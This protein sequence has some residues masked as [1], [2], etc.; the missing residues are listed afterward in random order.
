VTEGDPAWQRGGVAA[1]VAV[2][3][4]VVGYP[5]AS[6]GSC[7]VLLESGTGRVTVVPGVGAWVVA[8][9]GVGCPAASRGVAAAQSQGGD[10]ALRGSCGIAGSGWR[11]GVG[12][13]VV[14]VVV[15]GWR[16]WCAVHREGVARAV[17]RSQRWEPLTL[18]LALMA[19]SPPPSSRKTCHMWGLAASLTHS[20]TLSLVSRRGRVR[21]WTRVN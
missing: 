16:W 19:S 15:V 2:V 3:V 8:V 11:P 1:W 18:A 7:G 10:R 20:L 17:L 13:W 5:T 12:A 9:A 4:V 14:A 21:D 6:R